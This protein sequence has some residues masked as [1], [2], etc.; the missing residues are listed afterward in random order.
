ML[1]EY[2]T[3]LAIGGWYYTAAFDDLSETQADGQPVR[4]RGSSGFYALL[5]RLL[6]KNSEHP[7]QR[8]TGFLQAGFGDNRVNRFGSYLGGGLTVTGFFEARTADEI[9]FG[10]AYARNGSHYARAQTAQGAP[11]DNA[12]KSIELTYLLQLNS[13]L[14]LQPDVQYIINPNT[15]PA[16]AN[17]MA[18]QLRF[19]IMF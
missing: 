13:W 7:E 1:G 6:Y 14:A 2:D 19:E 5:D 12:E 3:K 17:A 11:V 8:L 4:H 16:L 15:T 9:G 18:V 10:L